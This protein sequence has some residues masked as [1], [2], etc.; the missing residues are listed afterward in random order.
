[1]DQSARTGFIRKFSKGN[2]TPEEHEAF[3]HWVRSADKAELEEAWEI[4]SELEE[5]GA[6]HEA[7]P[8]SFREA[9]E[10]RLDLVDS[11]PRIHRFRWFAAA[12]VLVLLAGISL[13][14]FLNW[15]K[16]GP[17]TQPAMAKRIDLPPGGNKATLTLSGGKTIS[18][19]DIQAGQV[20][21]ENGVSVRKDAD[22][23]LLY[24]VTG[25]AN[26]EALLNNTITTPRGGQYQVSLPDGSIVWLNA[27][28]SLSFPVNFTGK[29]R[30]VSIT[31]EAYFA[32][33]K[34]RNK[35]FI[36]QTGNQELEVLGTEFNLNSYDPASIMTSLVE[37]AVKV[38][39]TATAQ[40]LVLQPG[41][42]SLCSRRQLSSKGF[43]MENVTA[44]KKG[45]FS[46]TNASLETVMAEFERWY[47]VEVVI[48]GSIPDFDF[49]GQIPRTFSSERFLEIM[50]SYQLKFRMEAAGGKQKLIVSA[51]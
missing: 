25:K 30:K 40:E 49:T 46:F 1:M 13:F 38:S 6:D 20:A 5:A 51:P 2:F 37:G 45:L 8:P 33:K 18:L 42:Q 19:D 24:T 48:R 35:P 14:Y 4:F 16:S 9:L 32:I 21:L 7:P 15:Q 26:T 39:N 28:S 36:V 29:Q 47:D 3:V 23:K 12:S 44:W 50:S 41:R 34:N 27:A 10:R 31:G 22:G 11:P 43:D 17:V